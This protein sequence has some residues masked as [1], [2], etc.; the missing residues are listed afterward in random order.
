MIEVVLVRKV[1]HKI[2]NLSPI[3][4]SGRWLK[5]T[6]VNNVFF[7]EVDPNIINR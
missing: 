1:G 6:K 4:P 5:I 3:L 7:I 2:W